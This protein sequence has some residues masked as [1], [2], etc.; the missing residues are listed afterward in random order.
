MAGLRDELLDA[1]R[2]DTPDFNRLAVLEMNVWICGVCRLQL[3]PAETLVKNFHCE[4]TVDDRYDNA[5]MR[6]GQRAINED[7]VA[8]IDASFAH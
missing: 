6:R 3:G 7:H 2:D 8:V 4:L 5:A 1:G